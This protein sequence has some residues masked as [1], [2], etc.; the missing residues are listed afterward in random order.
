[1][2]EIIDN[3][4][5]LKN[6]IFLYL[7]MG[8]LM[9][10]SL[11]TS[12]IVL[13]VLGVEGYGVYNIVAG[14][15]IMFSFVNLTLQVAIRRFLA[16]EIG[17]GNVDRVFSIYKSSILSVFIVACIAVIVLETV[18][19][20]LL[21]YKLI[22][23]S[24]KLYAANVVYQ[25]SILTFVFN[26][27]T[28]PFN[29]AI[30]VYEKM[31]IYAYLGII[32]GVMK[33][34]I[35]FVLTI[36]LLDKLVLYAIM[37]GILSLIVLIFNIIYCQKKIL[38]IKDFKIHEYQSIKSIFIFSAWSVLG[39]IALMLVTQGVN[40]I[41][42][43]F[44]GVL[45]NATMGI[46]NQVTSAFNQFIGNFQTAF[47]PQLTKVYASEGISSNT[48]RFVCQTSKLS[49]ILILLLGFPIAL[50]IDAILHLW[51]TEVPPYTATFCLISLTVASIDG[52]AGALYMLVYAT[53]RIRLYQLVFM[54]IQ[55]VYVVIV[56]FVCKRGFS[57]IQ[58]MLMSI[59][60]AIVIYAVRLYL[61]RKMMP[62]PIFSY[63]S[64]ILL[65]LI[66]VVVIMVGYAKIVKP[67]LLVNSF[68]QLLVNLTI[69]FF[70]LL[71]CCY[72]LY[73]NIEE[74]RYVRNLLISKIRRK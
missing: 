48:F 13:L 73:L 19:L 28:V 6:A 8:L 54:I 34:L 74:K 37:I 65:P 51:L 11:Y 57:P 52:A 5:V 25:I 4:K 72:L 20:W 18:G 40:I 66:P 68:L 69:V 43:M 39:S 7:R 58:I 36:V 16:V 29:A 55:F 63:M 53:G 1:M 3:K 44:F 21:N 23:P 26:L 50:N 45:I 35:A 17:R 31:K 22:I 62:F 2:G 47:N 15:V 60:L 49:I 38:S 14:V 24:D 33:L 9:I 64:K 71:S 30:V 46:T 59:I 10:I 70:L 32:E 56:Y 67:F 41:F 61:L 42:N 27:C 12:R